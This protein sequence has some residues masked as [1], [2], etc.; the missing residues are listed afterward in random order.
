VTAV[1]VGDGYEC[2][3]CGAAFAAGLVRVPRAWG[4]G[5]EAMAAAAELGVPY[6]EVVVVEE[7]SLVAQN[8]AL[9]GGL[10][11]RPIVLGGCCCAHVGAVEGLARR[12]E[13]GAL[14]LVWVDAHGDLNTPETS[15]SGNAWGMPL[16][17]LLDGGAVRPDR[18]ALVAARDLDP[19][20]QAYM[21]EI[22]LPTGEDGVRRA[23]DGAEA[24]YV[25]FDVDALAPDDVAA[26]M[27]TP[28]GPSLAE[29]ERLLAE[30]SARVPVA[31]A[32]FTGL[33]PEARNVA[34]VALLAA[35]L[36]L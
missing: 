14:A 4:A 2:H 36:G 3:A 32:G 11:A 34:V 23:L 6:P 25:A 17:M 16:R 31:G 10:P 28:G 35:A 21:D 24:V 8:A 13:P 7:G 30:I 9:S 5:G 12:F 26:H 27:P 19:P 15:P 22:A 1:A 33:A 29:A 18:T 20:E